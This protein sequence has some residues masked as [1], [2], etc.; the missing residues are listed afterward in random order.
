MKLYE[1][2]EKYS[3]FNNYMEEMIES[4]EF[5]KE[6]FDEQFKDMWE[7][8]N[9]SLENKVENIVKLI[10]HREAEEEAYKKEKDRL[11]ARQKTANN[12]IEN[13]KKY[14]LD[15]LTL[16]NIDKVNAGVFK[17]R[18]QNNVPS[19]MVMD[20]KIIPEQYKIKQPDKI[21]IK[22]LTK[23]LKNG[24]VQGAVLVT[25]KQHIRIT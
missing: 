15:I 24:E 21:D 6:E 9:D 7:S 14:M 1:I 16:H 12:Q 19:A 8:I 22:Q 3:S 17:I 10:K 23:D 11:A 25:D 13:L 20:E 5:T 2:A 4:G 18:R